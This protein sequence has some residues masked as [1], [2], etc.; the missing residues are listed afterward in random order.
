MIKSFLLMLGLLASVSNAEELTTLELTIK[1]GTFTPSELTGPANKK[2]KLTIKNDGKS[3][4]EFESHELNR[5][6]VVSPG[7]SVS[8]FIGPLPAGTYPFFGEF[9]PETAKGKL[10][11]Q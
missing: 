9:H 1:D 11:L 8:V 5:E 2:I 4:E 7:Q 6:K 3:A 10:T